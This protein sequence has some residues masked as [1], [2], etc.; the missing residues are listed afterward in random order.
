MEKLNRQEALTR[1]AETGD[2]TRIDLGGVDLSETNLVRVDFRES[3]LEGANFRNSELTEAEF[4][5]ATMNG[6]D[7]SGA[8][9]GRAV[10]IGAHIV[11]TRFD[12]AQMVGAFLNGTIASGASF[13]KADLRAAR[14]GV[15]NFQPSNPFDAVT[16][17]EGADMTWCLFGEVD[18]TGVD[19]RNTNLSHAHM[20]ETEIRS[21]MLEGADLTNVRLKRHPM[22]TSV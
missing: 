15:P 12:G 4:R 14:I 8:K 17:F 2:L 1:A 7:F 13:R 19:L 16:S 21:A 10:L 6:A 9:M 18:L 20:Y 5:D 22:P 11:G 3:N